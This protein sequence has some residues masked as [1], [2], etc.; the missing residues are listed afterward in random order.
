[1]TVNR[2][3]IKGLSITDLKNFIEI[4]KIEQNKLD[5]EEEDFDALDE[6]YNDIIEYCKNEIT[7]RRNAIF[8]SPRFV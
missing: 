6:Y 5:E 7:S 2:D 3:L 4:T 1:M 8:G